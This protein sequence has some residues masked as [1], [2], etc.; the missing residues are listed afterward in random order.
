MVKILNG[1]YRDEAGVTTI[2]YALLGV[3]IA[4]VAI[5]MIQLAGNWVNNAFNAVANAFQGA[6]L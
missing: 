3:L 5:A 6:G 2:E 4:I 1:L